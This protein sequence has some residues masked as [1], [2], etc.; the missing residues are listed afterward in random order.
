MGLRFL[1]K[2]GGHVGYQFHASPLRA[3]IFFQSKTTKMR[4]FPEM[5]GSQ[6]WIKHDVKMDV[7]TFGNPFSSTGKNNI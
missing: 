1:Q 2:S 6:K 3:M 4:A 5:G 7:A